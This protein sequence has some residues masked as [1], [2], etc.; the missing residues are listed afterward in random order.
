MALSI[1]TGAPAAA[2]KLFRRVE[3]ST[4]SGRVA[5]P[6][7]PLFRMN[8]EFSIDMEPMYDL[9]VE[10]AEDGWSWAMIEARSDESS[11]GVATVLQELGI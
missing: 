10:Q 6:S 3:R 9:W 1:S 5:R 11:E 4:I 7:V 2:W 8:Y